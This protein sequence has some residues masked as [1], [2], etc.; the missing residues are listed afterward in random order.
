VGTTVVAY[1]R[2]DG[3]E[4]TPLGATI[5][6]PGPAGVWWTIEENGARGQHGIALLGH[7][8][9]AHEHAVSLRIRPVGRTRLRLEVS[10]FA[11]RY[12]R[13]FCDFDLAAG[14]VTP[15]EEILEG[16][17]TPLAEE[18]Y[19]LLLRFIPQA[20]VVEWLYLY[21]LGPGQTGATDG[22][23]APGFAIASAALSVAPEPSS[24][25][26]VVS[27][28][29]AHRLDDRTLFALQSVLL[30]RNYFHIEFELHRDGCR[31]VALDLAAKRPLGP[32]RWLAMGSSGAR[33]PF[34]CRPSRLAPEE[35]PTPI[36][37][38]ALLEALGPAYAN[39]GQAVYGLFADWINVAFE[40]PSASPE[41]FDFVLTVSFDDG[42]SARIVIDP[43]TTPT[44]AVSAQPPV[45][46]RFWKM[47]AARP[48]GRLLEVGGRG[49]KA[50]VNR[51]R[52]PP[53]WTYVGFDI[54][55]GENVDVIGDAH[56]LSRYFP[57]SSVD[58][59]FCD[60][61]L[62]HL[63]APWGF[64]L[65]ANTVLKVGGL[66]FVSTPSCAPLHA[67]PWDFYRFSDHCWGAMLNP[68]TGFEILDRSVEGPV[69]VVPRIPKQAGEER[70][71][72][73]PSYL[74]T[75]VLARKTGESRAEWAAYD[76]AYLFGAYER[77][78]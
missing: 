19:E 9:A 37:S 62:E 59:I 32:V 70:M 67:E 53:H 14:T 27:H 2:F 20:S 4:M 72:H 10:G 39:C 60:Q 5:R 76:P 44:L 63:F 33:V 42:S 11:T 35:P 41:L 46:N 43:S 51:E 30:V 52:L 22:L 16:R 31:P 3:P 17:I 64:L 28:N 40:S 21:A 58:V 73:D 74:L 61:I 78:R 12:Q 48:P 1:K 69:V 18:A 6:P 13:G 71:Q 49:P 57:P 45:V 68:A 47:V 25:S 66:L 75:S 77:Q 24:G 36:R 56:A 65:E 7:F 38:P 15:A 8:R 55:P 50:H 26:R 29:R 54:H 34:G 23:G